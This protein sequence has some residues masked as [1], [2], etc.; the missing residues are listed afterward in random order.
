[1]LQDET[2]AGTFIFIDLLK[3]MALFS[4]RGFRNNHYADNVDKDDI[5]QINVGGYICPKKHYKQNP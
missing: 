4:G 5:I 3:I 1:M 2:G